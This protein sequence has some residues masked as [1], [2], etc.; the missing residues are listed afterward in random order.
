MYEKEVL[1]GWEKDLNYSINDVIGH[2]NEEEDDHRLQIRRQ[3][4]G[5][6]WR[7]NNQEAILLLLFPPRQKFISFKIWIL[8]KKLI[9]I[10]KV[11]PSKCCLAMHQKVTLI[12]NFSMF[13]LTLKF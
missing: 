10:S 5:K 3:K 12:L 7:K 4:S 6:I 13:G 9:K 11:L 1:V 8:L 2:K